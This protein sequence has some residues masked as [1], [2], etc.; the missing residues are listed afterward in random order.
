[1]SRAFAL[2]ILAS[3]WACSPG[4]TAF[5][6]IEQPLCLQRCAGRADGGSGCC[7]GAAYADL[8]ADGTYFL[9]TFG[10]GTDT[11]PM[12]CAP[13]PIADGGWWY[14][15]D[16]Q[17]FGCGAVIRIRNPG[18]DRCAQVLVAD[19]GPGTCVEDAAC[20]PVLDATPLVA[21]QLFGVDASGWSEHRAVRVEV[22]PAG[23]LLG[24]CTVLADGGVELGDGGIPPPAQPHG[25]CGGLGFAWLPL[26]GLLLFSR[27]FSASSS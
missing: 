17:R 10:G 2:L 13:N 25:G 8:P 3:L 24:A 14:A 21:R 16:R 7:A 1:M 19:Y 6:T 27:R 20:G 11:G 4:E 9:T 15:A 23:S 5:S 22:L 26:F 18:N 12:S